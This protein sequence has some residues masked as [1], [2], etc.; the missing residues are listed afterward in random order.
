MN[1]SLLPFAAI[2]LLYASASSGIA[3][4]PR[5]NIV[6]IIADDLGYGDVGCY[7]DQSKIPTP[8]LD[9]LA[10]QGIRFTDAHS[11][12]GVCVP[13]R[14][15]L[16]TGRHAMHLVGGGNQATRPLI[17]EGWTTLP[18]ML[19]GAGYETSMIGKWHLGFDD[20]LK[21]RPN[22]S[23]E[24]RSIEVSRI[25]TASPP[26]STSTRICSSKGIGSSLKRRK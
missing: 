13:S 11:S 15:S 9:R 1:D 23:A 7:N 25:T 21:R 8:H 3:A 5:P 17:P 10:A 26:R 4:E 22:R 2:C 14:F 20:L 16:L 19:A 18:S 6:L 12:S 24:A